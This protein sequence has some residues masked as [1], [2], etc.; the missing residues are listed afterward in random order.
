MSF[1]VGQLVIKVRGDIPAH[2]Q[3]TPLGGPYRVTQAE[4]WGPHDDLSGHKPS[5]MC[6]AIRVDVGTYKN[7]TER[8]LFRITTRRA[9]EC[10]CEFRLFEPPEDTIQH[11]LRVAENLVNRMLS[12]VTLR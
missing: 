12:K 1:S 8:S 4:S 2:P 3:A 5:Y 9:F 6:Q 10:A 7:H 11:H